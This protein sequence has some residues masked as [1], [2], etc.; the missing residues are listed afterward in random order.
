ME[1]T[2][3]L[4]PDHCLGGI[5]G[6]TMLIFSTVALSHLGFHPCAENAEEKGLVIHILLFF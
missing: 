1:W 6:K 4:N 2:S 5:Y 3:L